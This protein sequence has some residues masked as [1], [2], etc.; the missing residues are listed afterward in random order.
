MILIM[1]PNSNPSIE[2]Y[3]KWISYSNIQVS[4]AILVLMVVE[5]QAKQ[6]T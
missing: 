6:A 2:N 4:A 3:F 5:K 1:I